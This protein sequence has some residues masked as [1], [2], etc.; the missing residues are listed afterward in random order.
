[1]RTPHATSLAAAALALALASN[2][3]PLT[4]CIRF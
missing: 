1:M 3:F 2:Y 4:L